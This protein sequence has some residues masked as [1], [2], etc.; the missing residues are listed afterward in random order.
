[1]LRPATRRVIITRIVNPAVEEVTTKGGIILPP[2]P[3]PSGLA[4]GRVVVAS[5]ACELMLH[6]NDIVFYH[7]HLGDT[8]T[9]EGSSYLV[10]NEHEIVAIDESR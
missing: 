3:S 5:P 6:A 2:T 8:I 1:M 9:H 10:L 4:K 7:A